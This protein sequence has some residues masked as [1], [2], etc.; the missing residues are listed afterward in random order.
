MEKRI[1]VIEKALNIL[2][3]LASEEN[4]EFPL[5]EIADTLNMDHGTCSNIIKTL[6]SRG[7]INQKGPRCGYKFG[8]MLYKLTNSAIN[9]EELTKIARDEIDDLG[10]KLNETAILSCI[11]NDKRIVLYKTVPDRELIVRTNVDKSIYSA[12]T[13][14]VIIANY[15]P[16]HLEKCLIRLGLPSKEEWPEIFTSDNPHGEL[17][18]SL[19][20]IRIAGY[21]IHHDPNGIVGVAAPIFKAGHVVGSLG[22]YMPKMRYIDEK[23]ILSTVLAS[24]AEINKK[25]KQTENIKAY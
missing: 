18:N 19:A 17:V 16:A 11:K 21:E 10:R 25:I 20:A 15:T 23:L 8:Y 24:A 14:R 3:L 12:N 7:Y 13:G 1:K 22:V 2:E 5:G 6:S 4:R 9:N